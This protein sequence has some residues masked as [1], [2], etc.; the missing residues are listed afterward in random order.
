[1]EHRIGNKDISKFLEDK[2]KEKCVYGAEDVTKQPLCLFNNISNGIYMLADTVRNNGKIVIHFDVDVDGVNCGYMARKFLAKC[3]IQSV[4]LE[5]NRNKK[6]GITEK[7]VNYFNNTGNVDLM[8]IVDSSSSCIETI[9]KCNFNVLVID[10]HKMENKN[11]MGYCN[12]GK[13]MYVI[14]N[15]TLENKLFYEDRKWL[16]NI[17]KQAFESVNEYIPTKDMS[18]GVTLY[19]FLRVY[20]NCVCGSDK[21]LEDMKLYQC[22]AITLFTDSIDTLNKRNQWYIHNTVYANELEVAFKMM[23]RSIDRWFSFCNKSYIAY[24]FAPVVNKSIRAGAGEEVMKIMLNAPENFD[25]LKKYEEQ[26]KIALDRVMNSLEE[27]ELENQYVMKNLSNLGISANYNGVIAQKLTDGGKN[28][29]AFIQTEKG[30]E[31]SFRGRNKDVDYNELFNKLGV[32]AEG[33]E[34]AFG[35]ETNDLGKLENVMQYVCEYDMKF[36]KTDYLSLGNVPEE[37]KG[38]YHEDSLEDF[39]KQHLLYYIAMGNADVTSADEINI[40]VST[41]DIALLEENEKYLKYKLLGDL[42]CIAFEKIEGERAKL[43]LEYTDTIRAFLR[44][45]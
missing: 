10:H 41:S 38:E 3:G 8:I 44:N 1:M 7:H 25:Y 29:V 4:R 33:H 36:F 37:Y 23:G 30:Y 24:K 19:E 9:K 40:I 18:C 21:L 45:Y 6:H 32:K 17:N 22:A 26:Q 27:H 20:M 15:N 43:Y 5:V 14:V 2:W 39:K 16:M 28:A 31:G 42:E 12:N 13:N 35:I 34:V 11:T